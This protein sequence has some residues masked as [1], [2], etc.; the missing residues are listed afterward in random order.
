MSSNLGKALKN[1]ITKSVGGGISNVINYKKNQQTKA[2]NESVDRHLNR[3]REDKE[4]M[5]K[6][7]K[8]LEK[9]GSPV[10][11]DDWSP[12]S[13]KAL[14]AKKNISASTEKM[15]KETL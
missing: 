1:K 2:I 7:R 14:Y 5:A 11:V 4:T 13:G 8:N 10:N 6:H 3:T 15:K 12:Q 9:W